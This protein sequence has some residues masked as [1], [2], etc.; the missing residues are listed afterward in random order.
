MKDAFFMIRQVFTRGWK[1][2]GKRILKSC[3]GHLKDVG[4]TRLLD[5]VLREAGLPTNVDNIP[6]DDEPDVA[7]ELERMH[8]SDADWY[9]FC[10]TDISFTDM[11]S[12]GGG[13]GPSTSQ[14][15]TQGYPHTRDTQQ[16][17]YGPST[18]Q[19][20]TQDCPHTHDTQQTPY[21]P[22]SSVLADFEYD[23]LVDY[24]YGTP[25]QPLME[26][27]DDDFVDDPWFDTLPL[28]LRRPRWAM[29]PRVRYTPST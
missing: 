29:H 12:R 16:T 11:L 26:H 14:P 18:S 15:F 22:S 6:T 10:T 13:A 21:G 23:I 7:P 24:Q 28:A 5:F 17:S 20:F 19:P 25:E 8:F 4:Q 1:L 2:I 9:S 27:A 3:R